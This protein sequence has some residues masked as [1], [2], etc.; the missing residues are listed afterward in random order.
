MKRWPRLPLLTLF[1]LLFAG[2]QNEPPPT[3][4]P[5]TYYE[6]LDLATAESAV[7]EFVAAF[8]RDDYQTLY[9]IF[10]F[11]TQTRVINKFNLLSLSE[12]ITPPEGITLQEIVQ[13][14]TLYRP[15]IEWEHV[16]LNYRFDD[17]MLVAKKYDAFMIDLRGEVTIEQT[18]PW[19]DQYNE[20]LDV[21]TRVEGIEGTV[22][23]RMVQAS[24]GRWRVQQVIVP[25]GDEENV[26][27]SI[28]EP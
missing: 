20:G 19:A 8:Q 16:T 12:L 28:P 22:T 2:C 13:E 9:L 7:Q 3:P 26:P 4:V 5:R 6:S 24:S 17:L 21:L 25:G 27:W 14:T 1:I 18:K 15:P 11:N 10:S 23:F